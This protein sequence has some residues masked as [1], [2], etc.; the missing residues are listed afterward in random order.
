MY[1]TDWF[2]T[3]LGLA[4]LAA[5]VPKDMDSKDMWPSISRNK[6]SP[7]QQIVLNLDQDNL[8]GLWSA[9]IIQGNYKLL[10]GQARLLKAEVTGCVP[11]TCLQEVGAACNTELY[12]L[13]EDPYE[14]VNLVSL[15]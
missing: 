8:R 14:K 7:R 6:R 13:K 4:G 5:S 15:F 9:A 10:W 1:I 2:A 3:L 11:S 12:N